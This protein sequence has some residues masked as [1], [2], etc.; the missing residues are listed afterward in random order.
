M[1]RGQDTSKHPNRQVGRPTPRIA[2]ALI[3]KTNMDVNA[4]WAQENPRPSWT[5]TPARAETA[6]GFIDLYRTLRDHAP[7]DTK[8]I[9]DMG[10]R[11]RDA[12]R[13]RGQ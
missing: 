8:N 6:Q 11:I 3:R 9:A 13:S 4:L 2:E 1:P 7:S 5:P 10:G 12:I